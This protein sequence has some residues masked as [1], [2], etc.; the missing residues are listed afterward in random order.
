MS[1]TQAPPSPKAANR[2]YAIT[3]TTFTG[4]TVTKA[5]RC[6]N[7]HHMRRKACQQPDCCTVGPIRELTEEQFANMATQQR[8]HSPMLRSN[9]KNS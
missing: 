7:A 9:M 8:R 4:S 2:P 1:I 5:W 3:Y 6:N